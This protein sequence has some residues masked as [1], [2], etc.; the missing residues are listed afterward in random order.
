MIADFPRSDWPLIVDAI[1]AAAGPGGAAFDLDAAIEIREAMSAP[2]DWDR[3]WSLAARLI[4][5]MNDGREVTGIYANALVVAAAQEL[6]ATLAPECPPM[7]PES[8]AP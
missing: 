1:E 6:D 4:V 7:P 3:V 2:A 8:G 5:R